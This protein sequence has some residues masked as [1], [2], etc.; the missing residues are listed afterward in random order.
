MRK[1]LTFYTVVLSALEKA[2]WLGAVLGLAAKWNLL[3][4]GNP[5]LL[6][7]LSTLGAVYFLQAYAPRS[8]PAELAREERL[9][10]G[11]SQP[12]FAATDQTSNFLLDKVLP[13]V[14]RISMAV[15]LIGILFKLLSWPGSGPMLAVSAA[16]IGVALLLL[17]FN[18]RLD[19]RALLVGTLAVTAWQ[20]PSETLIR[21][22]H[23][24]D[25]ALVEKLIYQAHHPRD[26]AAND[27]VRQYLRQK[28]ARP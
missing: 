4:S 11:S 17:G 26:S 12:Y 27:A 23:R 20:V 19:R 8:T 14:T 9:D 22:F 25:P 1:G 7:G 18:Q 6:F 21:Q 15:A 2:A 3:A 28:R 16:I 5:L 10:T 13:K 24:D